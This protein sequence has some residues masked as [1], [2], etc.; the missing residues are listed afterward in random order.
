MNTP[1]KI[2]EFDQKKLK[3]GLDFLLKDADPMLKWEPVLSEVK[4]Y[5]IDAKSKE[6]SIKKI[7]KV[8]KDSGANMPIEVLKKYMD[9]NLN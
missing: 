4:S 2:K 9:L 7:H 3:N 5:L 6:I 8:F 1:K